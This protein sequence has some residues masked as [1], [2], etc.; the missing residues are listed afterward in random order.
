MSSV[1]ALHH[2]QVRRALGPDARPRARLATITNAPGDGHV[3][4][5]FLDGTTTTV[6]VADA[7]R[8]TA[9]LDRADL[10]RLNGQPFILLSTHNGVLAVA[11]GPA[12]PPDRLV[13][14]LVSRLEDGAVVELVGDG[15]QPAWQL[16]AL[17]DSEPAE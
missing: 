10:C 6:N 17:A 1:P 4:V 11:T 5:R 2:T 13:V 3:S 12:A 16:F 7:A 15:D 14:T 8:L 9:T